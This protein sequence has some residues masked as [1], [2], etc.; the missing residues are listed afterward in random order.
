VAV[1]EDDL[2]AQAMNGVRPMAGKSLP[3]KAV[4]NQAPKV[5]SLAIQTP[6]QVRSAQHMPSPQHVGE[7]TLRA[8]GIAADVLKKLACGKPPINQSLDL[9]GMNR[10]QALINLEATCRSLIESKQRVLRVIHGR[11]LHSP[12]GRCIIKRAVYDFLRCGALSG[13]VLATIPCPKS[14]GGA[15]LILL[16]RDK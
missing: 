6:K 13:Y 15:C 5:H 9:H 16:R 10:E 1:S 14:S 3:K 8:N 4:S 2:F 12:D 7:W 11:G